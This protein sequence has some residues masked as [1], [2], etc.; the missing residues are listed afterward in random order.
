MENP[1]KPSK[2]KKIV[3]PL[4]L[5][6]F[7]AFAGLGQEQPIKIVFDV[8]SSNPDV[9]RSAARHLDLESEAYPESEFEMVVYSGA[10][11]LVKKDAS[12]VLE[13]LQKVLGRDNVSIKVC[14]MTMDRHKMGMDDLI[15]G[16]TAVPDGIYE[17]ISKQQQGWGYIKEGQ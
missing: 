1:I 6:L 7:G 12:P 16:I 3:F 14:Q 4:I 2:M 10:I 5:F 11:D 9:H 17:I 13:T 8:S 15:P